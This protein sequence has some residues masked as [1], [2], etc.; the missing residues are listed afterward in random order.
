[1]IRTARPTRAQMHEPVFG[2]AKSQYIYSK[3]VF[4][5]KVNPHRPR[6]IASTV[7]SFNI[8]TGLEHD[9]FITA[10]MSLINRI[11]PGQ[12][13]YLVHASKRTLPAAPPPGINIYI[14]IF[15]G[16]IIETGSYICAR[17]MSGRS[18]HPLPSQS[19]FLLYYYVK[20]KR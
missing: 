17:G 1:M 10:H 4:D 18:A 12:N 16:K 13:R 5:K 8:L 2:R 15:P 6:M 11:S 14:V 19:L 7:T 9:I 3:Y 20:F